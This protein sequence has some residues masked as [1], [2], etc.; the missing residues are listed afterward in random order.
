MKIDIH[1][2]VAQAKKGKPRAQNIILNTYWD[3]VY[4]YVFSKIKNENDAEDIAIQTFTKAFSKLKLY[5]PDFDFKTWLISISHNTMLDFL[6]KNKITLTS[7]MDFALEIPIEEPSPE[8]ELIN[9]QKIIEIKRYVKQ[10]KPNYRKVI[11]M[12]YLEEKTY[13]EIAE[14]LNLSISNVKIQVLR[15]KKLLFELMK[16]QK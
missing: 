9:K 13:K 10:L 8:E 16:N 1:E 12:R 14:E 5:N 2:L 7:D 6:K 4:F 3:N 15:G 11:Q